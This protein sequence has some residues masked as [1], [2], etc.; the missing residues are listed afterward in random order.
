MSNNG[1]TNGNG[2]GDM[3]FNSRTLYDGNDR[4]GARAMMKAIGFTDEDLRK[5]II[6]IANTWIE[7]MPCNYNLRRLAEVVKKGVRAAGGTPM[8]F[9]TV[10]ISDGVTMGTEGMKTS[11][12][13]RE[14]IADSLE[15]V[16]RGHMF[17]GIIA[18]GA[19]DKTLPGLAMGLA[20]LNVPSFTLY[21]GSIMPGFWNGKEVTIRSVYEAIGANAAGKM[22]DEDL[23]DLEN[24]ACPG[25]GACGGQYTANT[26]AM[27]MEFLGMS[28]IGTASPPAVD[29]RKEEVGEKAGA[30]IM[31]L[32]QRNVRPR[33]VLTRTAFENAI[34]GVC[35]TGGSTNSV[36]HLLALAREC[37]V[38]LEIDDFD[39]ISQRTPLIADMM[40][41]GKYAAADLDKAG[42]IQLVAKRMVEAGL[43]DGTA[44]T[45]SGK[46]LADE[47]GLATETAGQDV[48]HAVADPIKKSGGL[49]ILKGNL[50]P[51]GAVVKLF[52]YEHTYHKGPARVFDSEV[53]AH[54]AVNEGKINDGDVVVIRYEGPKGG[55]GMQEMLS[56]TAAIVGQGHGDTVAL[57]TDGRFSG[58]T[59]GLMLGHVA[60]EAQVGGPIAALKEG[61]TIVI[62]AE[63]RSLS[64]E[65]SEDELAARLRDWTAPPIKYRN[66]VMAK[67]ALLVHQADQGATTLLK[68]DE[69]YPE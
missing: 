41:G 23:V 39:E 66:G 40:P 53:E 67:Y 11:L 17:D 19:C 42:G 22:S 59:R 33:D 6:G 8:E 48:V 69:V 5:P 2:S 56:V 31:D 10:A 58:A 18:L 12:M 24:H 29:P 9:N 26:M 46:S 21:G 49:H 13:S 32:L 55:P 27:A 14:V 47:A 37:G 61:D 54:H 15:L 43:I 35:A 25:A 3:R 28:P 60:P 30:V 34:A 65:L 4:A 68:P 7:T 1:K 51:D 20:R 63:K 52:G 44:I 64:V 57:I 50:A 36:L 45:P 38:P 16:G 62:D